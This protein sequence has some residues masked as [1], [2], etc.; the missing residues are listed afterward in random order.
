MENYRIDV[1]AIDDYLRVLKA[2]R[3]DSD[4]KRKNIGK[5]LE[6][7]HAH[8]DDENYA[9]TERSMQEI[10]GTLKELYRSVEAAISSLGEMKR[11]YE[12]YLGRRKH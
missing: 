1:D 10:D 9:R 3:R 4:D 8:W 12:T 6:A 11:R 2:F 7:A 5:K